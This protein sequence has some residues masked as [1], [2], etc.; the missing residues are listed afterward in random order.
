MEIRKGNRKDKPSRSNSIR[1]R[2]WRRR[3]RVENSKC[4]IARWNK[5][6]TPSPLFPPPRLPIPAPCLDMHGLVPFAIQSLELS[7][8]LNFD[9]RHCSRV[10][11]NAPLYAASITG[12]NC[13]RDEPCRNYR[14]PESEFVTGKGRGGGRPTV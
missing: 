2:K 12:A 5:T 8:C 6:S 7:S 10:A 11:G 14:T 1:E 13:G 4:I 9:R 3:A